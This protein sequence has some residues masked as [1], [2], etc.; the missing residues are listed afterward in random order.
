[1]P[2]SGTMKEGETLAEVHEY[3]YLSENKDCRANSCTEANLSYVIST[4]DY[5]QFEVLDYLSIKYEE[6]QMW[7]LQTL[8]TVAT[9]LFML[10]F[11][12]V[13]IVKV[14]TSESQ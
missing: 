13:E 14:V 12:V 8:N 3:Q 10:C 11:S 4:W 5:F 6:L 9:S 2:L 7:L 1:M